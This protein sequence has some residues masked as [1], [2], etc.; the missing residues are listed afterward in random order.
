MNGNIKSLAAFIALTK[1]GM[2]HA[3][4]VDAAAVIFA[5]CFP[6][7][8]KAMNHDWQEFFD[9]HQLDATGRPLPTF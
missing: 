8:F 2:M 3:A 6:E 9:N 4:Q 1:L 5:V 7:E